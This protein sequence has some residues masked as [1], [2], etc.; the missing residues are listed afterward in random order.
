MK[1][2]WGR[3]S[4]LRPSVISLAWKMPHD[5]LRSAWCLACLVTFRQ[6][7][8]FGIPTVRNSLQSFCQASF[9]TSGRNFEH[10]WY[11][12]PIKCSLP[13]NVFLYFFPLFLCTISKTSTTMDCY[14]IQ[15]LLWATYTSC[16]LVAVI[17]KQFIVMCIKKSFSILCSPFYFN[18]EENFKNEII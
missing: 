10:L 14:M 7:Q 13:T 2:Y 15:S 12:L 3:C 1:M 4:K 5:V 9:M 17:V 11:N 18:Y 8:I 16:K 6:L